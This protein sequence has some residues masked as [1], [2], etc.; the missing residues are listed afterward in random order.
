MDT[1][2]VIPAKQKITYLGHAGWM[3]ETAHEL[4]IMDPWLSEH[5]AYDS[6]WFQY[7]CNHHLADVV[8]QKVEDTFK[9]VYVYISHEHQDHYDKDFLESL[10]EDKVFLLLPE[11]SR[12]F[13]QQQYDEWKGG[14]FFFED[15]HKFTLYDGYLEFYIHDSI[16][17]ADSAVLYHCAGFNF[18]NLND[19]HIHDRVSEIVRKN[20][21]KL[22]VLT[23][24]FSGASWFPT[25]YYEH[26]R[27]TYA[28]KAR[29]NK[30]ARF[31]TLCKLI[32][33]VKP[34]RYVPSAGPACFLDLDLMPFNFE[35]E[36]IFPHACEFYDFW[37]KW[38]G[39]LS[40]T[41]FDYRDPGSTLFFN[42]SKLPP[43][44]TKDE[45]RNELFEYWRRID[46]HLEARWERGGSPW[47][48]TLITLKQHFELKLDCFPLASQIDRP[49]IIRGPDGEDFLEV[50]FK[51]KTSCIIE[52][53]EGYQQPE[54]FYQITAIGYEWHNLMS[55]ELTWYEWLLALRFR[56]ERKPDMFDPLLDGFLVNEH[57]DLAAFCQHYKQRKSDE[58]ITVHTDTKAYTVCRKCPHEGADLTNGFVVNGKLVCPKH[59]WR[60]DLE[61]GGKCHEHGVS[62]DA[63]EVKDERQHSSS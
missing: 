56:V 4:I 2:K 38:R 54:S 51:T 12:K 19:C 22:D 8:R 48:D 37:L 63:Q 16:R 46:H 44:K 7:P 32:E 25:C 1:P 31:S 6:A 28:K 45:L 34:T 57:E 58:R 17:E 18:L 55:G 21:G 5:G 9:R 20:G 49:L 53:D 36:N 52:A 47:I 10:P 15:G 3:I 24:H 40:H 30:I 60:F 23:G 61:D 59:S 11:F 33:E 26:D 35:D 50:D 43:R 13:F 27:K 14:V 39:D 41:N 29:R 62:I 42:L